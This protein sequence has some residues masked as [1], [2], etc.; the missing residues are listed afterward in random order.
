MRWS[1][2]GLILLLIFDVW[3]RGHTF[4]PPLRDRLGITL[5]PAAVGAS[6]PLDCDEA[7][8]AYIGHRILRGDVMYRDLTENKPPLG[9]WL[10]TLAVA[11]GGYSEL[12]VRLL[13][14]PF[15]LTSIALVWWIGLRLGG[16]AAAF[17]AGGVYIVLSTD[18]YLFG[19]GSNLEHF[20]NCFAIGSLALL[21]FGWDARTDGISWLP[22]SAWG[23]LRSSSRS[24][25]RPSSSSYPPSSGEPGHESRHGEA[26]LCAAWSTSV[27][28]DSAWPQSWR[29]PRRS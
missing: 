2:L 22:A 17:L 7:A 13:P 6:E 12:A 3:Y 5:W 11:V 27:H 29:L 24:A 26:K 18:P 25:S 20:M 28:S 10:Y 19:N 23:P 16:R 9:Y 1:R 21:I 15:V 4:G 8:Y 14:L